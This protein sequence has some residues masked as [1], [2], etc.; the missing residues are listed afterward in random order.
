MAKSRK[1]FSQ[2]CV[3]WLITTQKKEKKAA[4]QAWG[5]RHQIS[6]RD[7]FCH[8]YLLTLF[9]NI[10]MTIWHK[11]G[12]WEFGLVG[13]KHWFPTWYSCITSG[14]PPLGKLMY[15]VTPI[16]IMWSIRQHTFTSAGLICIILLV[17]V[18]VKV[19]WSN[20]CYWSCDLIEPNK[21]LDWL[22]V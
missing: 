6:C 22:C 21:P 17:L 1:L 7:T 5:E 4:P 8:L 18:T 9:D 16:V 20:F 19:N 15:N 2:L 3:H 14:W 12:I 11:F 13:C 10:S